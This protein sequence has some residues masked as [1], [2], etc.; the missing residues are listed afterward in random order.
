MNNKEKCT[1]LQKEGCVSCDQLE[2][3]TLFSGV[4][5]C[6]GVRLLKFKKNPAFHWLGNVPLASPNG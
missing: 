4:T 5:F 1:D 3:M 2:I 6:L